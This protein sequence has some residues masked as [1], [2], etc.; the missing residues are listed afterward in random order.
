MQGVLVF[1]KVHCEKHGNEE[2]KVDAGDGD[3]GRAD[4]GDCCHDHFD[5]GEIPAFPLAVD[6]S[7]QI[8]DEIGINCDAD[9]AEEGVQDIVVS[10]Q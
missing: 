10:L 3:V 1:G 6:R 4:D 2:G 7:F 9:Q 8:V 5:V